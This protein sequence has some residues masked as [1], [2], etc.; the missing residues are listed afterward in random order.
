[1]QLTP[2]AY[3]LPPGLKPHFTH[4]STQILNT[5]ILFQQGFIYQ[6]HILIIGGM[7]ICIILSM[8][9][10]VVTYR[11]YIHPIEHNDGTLTR[12][13]NSEDHNY[14]RRDMQQIGH[15]YPNLSF[16]ILI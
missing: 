8:A 12:G 7:S 6:N 10:Q 14:S 2:Y 13:T 9:K 3:H 5:F 4:F 11:A 16:K 15:N 1:M